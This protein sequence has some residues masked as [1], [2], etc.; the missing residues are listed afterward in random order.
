MF[1]TFWSFSGGVYGRGMSKI[2]ICLQKFSTEQRFQKQIFCEAKLEN[3]SKSSIY[4]QNIFMLF[5]K[6]STITFEKTLF[7]ERGCLE[8]RGV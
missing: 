8:E 3:D 2:G 1:K 6:T 5:G 7:L 4:Q